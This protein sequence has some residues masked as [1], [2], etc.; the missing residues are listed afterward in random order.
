M[1]PT[2]VLMHLAIYRTRPEVNAVMHTHPKTTI[3][4]TA[5]GHDLRPMYADYYVYLGANVPHLPYITVT[6]PELARA[7]EAEFRAVD[8]VGMILRNHGVITVGTSIREAY[9]RTLAVEEQASI[10]WQA[11]QVG[12]PTFLSEEEC[13]RLDELGS[14]Q[15]RR[16]LLASMKS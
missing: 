13:A 5:A 8:C 14:E 3:A 7:V 11:L 10:Q 4:L 6:T 16:Q 1:T 9:F 2:E 15:Y 12:A